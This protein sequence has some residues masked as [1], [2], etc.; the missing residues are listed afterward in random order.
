MIERLPN[1]NTLV[2]Q[3]MGADAA[4]LDG[5]RR[6]FS[7][8][9]G[10]TVSADHWLW[11]YGPGIGRSFNWVAVGPDGPARPWGHVGARVV[12]G[13]WHGQAARLVHLTDVMVHPGLRGNLQPDTVYARLMR[14][15]AECLV[16]RE[17]PGVLAWGFPGLTPARLGTRMGLYRPL[18]RISEYQVDFSNP[19]L[20]TTT[21]KCWPIGRVCRVQPQSWDVP[22]LN[23]V[24][25]SYTSKP[26]LRPIRSPG[27]S[28]V[29]ALMGLPQL[30]VQKD[31]AYCLWRYR[32]HPAKPYRLWRVHGPWWQTL[33]WVVTRSDPRP[34]VVDALLP[35]AWTTGKAWS[36]VLWGLSRVSGCT[37]W[38]T[39]SPPDPGLTPVRTETS[40]IVPVEFLSSH[41]AGRGVSA[42]TLTQPRSNRFHVPLE[43]PWQRPWFQPGDT[44][45]F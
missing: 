36:A 34:L 11:K 7:D 39:W 30:L 29:E 25:Q 27:R 14:A 44:D 18:Q 32:D 2:I 9:F 5:V 10:H 37:E 19:R 41:L 24:W 28:S 13:L 16:D 1:P 22:W 43:S 26:R 45:V 40:L 31:A 6:L 23:G 20:V 35:V 4:G 21:T 33:G 17:G 8:V 42:W 15:M 12:P 38:T 3:P